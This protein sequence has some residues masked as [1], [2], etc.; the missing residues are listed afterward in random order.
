MPD[1]KTSPPGGP[2]DLHAFFARDPVAA[3]RAFFGRE[4]FP[5]RRGFLRGA[6]L[7][8]MAAMVGAA[9]PFHRNLPAGLIP[10]AFAGER[11]LV[12]KDGLT[13]LN[14]RP[15][16]AETPPHLLDD[17]ITPTARHFVRNNGVPPA[18]VDA[19][20]WTLTV[21]GQVERPVT[22]TIADLRS[23][24]EAVTMALVIECGGNGRAFFVP[25]ADGAQWTYGAVG[26]SRWT[27]VLLA[28]LLAA[29]EVR[30][31]VVY[32][33]H[34]GADAHLSG[35]PGKLPISRG[36]P[37]AKAMTGNVLVAFA[38][39]DGPIHPLNGAPL[40]L[41]VPGWPGSC[42]QKWLTRIELRDVVHDG[43]KMTG[44]SYRVPRRKVAPGEKVDETDFRI[45]ER[46]PVKSLITHPANGT[47][48]GRAV[49]VRGH[50][51]SGDR[52]VAAV[53]VSHDFGAT[54]RRAELDA[55]VNDGAWQGFR[56][57]LELPAAGYYELW[58]RATDS[59]GVTQPHAIDWNP[60]GYLNNTMHRVAV[61]AA[62]FAARGGRHGGSLRHDS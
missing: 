42:S 4:S 44:T 53:D 41:V 23:K 8:T 1:G 57:G 58:A 45:I 43:P 46:M 49:E 48:A 60:K 21:D 12:G 62:R 25:P 37:I 20:V 55:P 18:R 38:Q 19:G 6:G 26:C 28:D 15:V 2:Q 51:W 36:V 11:V 39:N 61:R 56:L 14:D 17:P 5:D 22:Y 9:I 3:D 47:G 7:A 27:G 24:F 13:L 33:A 10:A 34:Y 35:E 29:A 52:Q 30:P 32:T 31:N 50:A 54:W 16:N 40:R 59:Q